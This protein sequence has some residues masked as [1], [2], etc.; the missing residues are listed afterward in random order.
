MLARPHRLTRRAD[1]QRVYKSGKTLNT[2]LFRIKT[3]PNG[4]DDSRFGVVV[5]NKLIS[6]AVQRNRKKR[7]VRAVL[8]EIVPGVKVGY[9]IV[10]LPQA[11]AV[12]ARTDDM[13]QDLIAGLQKIGFVAKGE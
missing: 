2:A 5:P 3:A 12:D 7:Q 6:S 10:V 1:F 9:D 8:L 11:A 13:K 4:R